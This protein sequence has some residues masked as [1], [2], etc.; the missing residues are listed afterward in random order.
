MSA[1]LVT[2]FVAA[3][4]VAMHLVE[5]LRPGRL[6]PKVQGWWPRALLLNAIQVLS[7]YVA[8]MTTDAWLTERRPWSAD[9]LGMWGGV[10]VGYVIH[11]L[12]YYWWHRARHE[13]RLLW[14]WVHQVHHSP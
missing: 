3:L 6:S 9:V 1:L 5:R 12:V 2:G 14:R 4:A 11:S 10:A 7:V 13:V 8:G